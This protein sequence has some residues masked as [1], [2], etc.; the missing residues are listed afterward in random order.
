MKL[1]FAVTVGIKKLQLKK[2]VE[3]KMLTKKYYRQSI[4]ML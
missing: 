2:S 3:R 4:D 1:H